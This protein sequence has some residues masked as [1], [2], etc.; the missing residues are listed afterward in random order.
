MS[1]KED[2]IYKEITSCVGS[3]ESSEVFMQVEIATGKA[4]LVIKKTIREVYPIQDYDKV[5]RLH[6]RLNAGGGRKCWS[7]E[8]LT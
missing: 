2:Y 7:L 8:D 1:K 3:G 5:M 6:E 4:E